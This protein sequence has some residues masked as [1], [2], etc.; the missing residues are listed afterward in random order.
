MDLK[1]L[2]DS[3]GHALL[4]IEE[5]L[6]PVNDILRDLPFASETD[7]LRIDMRHLHPERIESIKT[8]L[9]ELSADV[10]GE[11][12]AEEAD[13]RFARLQEF[14]D[15]ID[16]PE[17]GVNPR[18]DEVLDVRRHIEITA[19]RID[20]EGREVSTYSTLGDKSGGESQELVAF[21]VGAAL[22]YQLGDQ[23]RSWPRFAPVFLDE[24]FVKADSAFT[25]RAISAWL[26]LGF[27]IIVVAPLDKVTTLEP[28]M[29][30]NLSVTK[31]DAGYSFITAFRDVALR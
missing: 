26:G 25:G 21:I 23:T 18:R 5:R 27:Q 12:T 14:I 17:S 6:E 2:S 20:P 28:H 30:L 8:Q 4:S 11:W 24:G 29:G 9:R 31:N 1:M 16:L 3:F 7:R 13:R 22:R 19:S 10:T 15:L